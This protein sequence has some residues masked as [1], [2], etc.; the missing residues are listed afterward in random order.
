MTTHSLIAGVCP[1]HGAFSTP[2][3]VCPHCGTLHLP[4]AAPHPESAPAPGED[5][6]LR[7]KLTKAREA[8]R[9]LVDANPIFDPESYTT[10]MRSARAALRDLE[11]A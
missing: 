9:A 6:D 2:R 1:R 10:A 4:V 5:G 7:A 11:G 8:L 3:G